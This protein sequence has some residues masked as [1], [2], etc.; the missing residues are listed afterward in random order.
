MYMYQLT[1]TLESLGVTLSSAS[2]IMLL[3]S[4]MEVY[5]SAWFCTSRLAMVKT[6]LARSFC[7]IPSEEERLH[8]SD[9][10]IHVTSS[11][12]CT[13]VSQPCIQTLS[14]WTMSFHVYM[15]ITESIILP[16]S[17]WTLS[18]MVC[19]SLLWGISF[20]VARNTLRSVC[21]C[22]CVCVCGGGGGGG[23]VLS[24]YC[25]TLVKRAKYYRIK[26]SEKRRGAPW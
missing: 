26:D 25:L 13:D 4:L 21:V 17:S 19:T 24:Y 22:V 15:H 20:H 12:H 2:T 8:H 14:K 16:A 5:R 7:C 10:I 18:I 23:G 9:I 11:L 3:M 6:L 1:E